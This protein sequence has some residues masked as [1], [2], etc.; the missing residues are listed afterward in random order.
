MAK[1]KDQFDG[2]HPDED[3]LMVFRRHPI[4]M[5]RGLIMVLVGALIGMIPVAIWPEYK[6]FVYLPIGMLLGGIFLF[7]DWIGWYFSVVIVTD[8]RLVQITQKGLFNRTVADISLDKIMSVNYQIAG[9]QETLLQFGTILIQTFVGDMMLEQVHH[10]ENVQQEITGILKELG[11]KSIMP[12]DAE[13][14]AG[15]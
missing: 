4:V 12:D 1:Q 13:A 9:I 7:R 3:V 14:A 15:E 10:P 5:R 8:Q 2:Q 6:N 11:I